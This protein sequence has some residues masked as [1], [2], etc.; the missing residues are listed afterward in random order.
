MAP[1]QFTGSPSPRSQAGWTSTRSRA[2][3]RLPHGP[4]AVRGRDA[5]AD[6]V[7]APPRVAAE[8][9][10]AAERCRDG[11]PPRP[12]QEPRGP[13]RL[14]GRVHLRPRLG[15]LDQRGAHGANRRPAAPRGR[16]AGR[17]GACQPGD[18]R[19]RRHRGCPPRG[20]H[21][22]VRRR[23]R[24]SERLTR[25][26]RH[27]ICRRIRQR[28]QRRAN[29]VRVRRPVPIPT[30]SPVPTPPRRP[31]RRSPPRR[32]T[33]APDGHHR[34]QGSVGGDGRRWTDPEGHRR[35]PDAARHR[36]GATAACT[37]RPGRATRGGQR[38][39]YQG[40]LRRREALGLRR[41]RIPR[42][43]P[44]V[45]QGLRHLRQRARDHERAVL[46]LLGGHAG[47]SPP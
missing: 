19:R 23:R 32:G 16:R 7:R 45:R 3:P 38:L 26:E 43:T 8:P 2:S 11:P 9:A 28:A 5:R 17:V 22:R 36:H 46:Q 35:V 34:H 6:D 14:G 15:H 29:A 40:R 27:A 39:R 33:T 21:A 42:R 1:E 44:P 25:P 41:V 24:E 47:R 30:P 12:G 13:I 20:R 31:Q 37:W 4:A 10:R 18:R